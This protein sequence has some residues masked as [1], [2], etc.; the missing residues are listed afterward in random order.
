[1]FEHLSVRNYR[2]YDKG[3]ITL[4]NEYKCALINEHKERFTYSTRI[5]YS[6]GFKMSNL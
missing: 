5:L 1:M 4:T 6:I 3:S 2:T